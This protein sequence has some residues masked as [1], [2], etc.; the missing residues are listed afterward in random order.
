MSWYLKSMTF[1]I[2]FDVI[3]QTEICMIRR[4]HWCC[5]ELFSEVKLFRFRRSRSTDKDRNNDV[6]QSSASSSSSSSRVYYIPATRYVGIIHI[7]VSLMYKWNNRT[8][9]RDT[10]DACYSGRIS[11]KYTIKTVPVTV[12][13]ELSAFRYFFFFYRAQTQRPPQWPTL[14]RRCRKYQASISLS[15]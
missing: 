5:G 1:A 2:C 10:S 7:I 11:W 13:R 6:L 3:I 9:S 14:H 8:V 12:C 15:W 4:G